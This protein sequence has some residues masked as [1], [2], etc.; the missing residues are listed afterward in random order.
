MNVVITGSTKGIGK[1]LAEE[2]FSLGDNVIISSRTKDAVDVFVSELNNRNDE[3][4]NHAYGY[5]CD[6]S[7]QTQ[8]HNLANFAVEKLRTV[9]IWINNAGITN[10]QHELFMDIPPEEIHRIINVNVIGALYGT[11]QA[12]RIMKTQ[13]SGK[14]FNMEGLGSRGRAIPGEFIYGYI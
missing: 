14:I 11:Q 1:A 10:L 13:E 4:S 3:S 7:N 2:F 8:I 9:D 6:V 12:L 5:V